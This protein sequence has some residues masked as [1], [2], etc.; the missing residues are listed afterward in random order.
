[1]SYSGAYNHQVG[2]GSQ[3]LQRRTTAASGIQ[4]LGNSPGHYN[5]QATA[6]GVGS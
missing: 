6:R 5:M 4:S 3:C 2:L 1:M